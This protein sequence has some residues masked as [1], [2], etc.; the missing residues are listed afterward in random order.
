MSCPL[1]MLLLLRTALCRR[2]LRLTMADGSVKWGGFV[3][4]PVGPACIT[5]KICREKILISNALV[6][7][8]KS[9]F[10]KI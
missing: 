2:P 9:L 5:K 8:L 4:A 3:S 7:M 6:A 10:V 1:L